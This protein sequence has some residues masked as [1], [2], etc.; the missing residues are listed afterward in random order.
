[1][2]YVARTMT[3]SVLETAFHDVHA[4][5][6][7]RISVPVDLAPRGII[8]LATPQELTFIDLRDDAL[9]RLGLQREHL[10]STT[11]AHYA[12]T[13]E[14]AQRLVWRHV[15][16]ARPVG[17]LWNSRVAELARDDHFL[18]QDLLRGEPAE[19][20]MIIGTPHTAVVTDLPR[21]HHEGARHLPTLHRGE[22]R[23][24]IEEIATNLLHATIVDT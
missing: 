3:V 1:V 24:I 13:R 2:L 19:V 16:P 9:I 7:R 22:G 15:G 6:P 18:L 23:T 8:E 21:W 4:Q 14:W 12:C 11:P 10:V 17:L 5:S 20:A